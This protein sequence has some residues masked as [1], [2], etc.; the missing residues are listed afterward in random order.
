MTARE[1]IEEELPE[2]RPVSG[3]APRKP[4]IAHDEAAEDEP[5]PEPGG[6]AGAGDGGARARPE[7]MPWWHSKVWITALGLLGASVAPLTAWL[8]A[9]QA[10]KLEERRQEQEVRI[11]FFE[12]VVTPSIAMT[13]ESRAEALRYFQAVLPEGDLKKW[14][15]VEYT[16]LQALIADRRR[17]AEE[18]ALAKA[19]AAA[20]AERMQT[21]LG[22]LEAAEAA[23][24][25]SRKALQQEID[26][27]ASEA[28]QSSAKV[29]EVRKRYDLVERKILQ[30]VPPA[31]TKQR[32][33][34]APAEDAVGPAPNVS[35]SARRSFLSQSAT[36]TYY[37]FSVSLEAPAG[38]LA[39]FARVDYRFDHPTFSQK[40][41]ASEDRSARF[42]VS[43]RGW[44]CLTK[45]DADITL[46]DGRVLHRSFDMCSLL[47]D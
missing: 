13:P 30:S 35:F 15:E 34:P 6:A 46:V 29:E 24:P 45:V 12:K 3:R 43:Y 2:P 22:Q 44:G 4:V 26:T 39:R 7:S 21:A 5:E 16:S 19:T 1:P 20:A 33:L 23:S 31:L 27:Q 28:K 36:A 40:A 47:R 9:E 11:E 17:A 37:R 18:E 8:S 32:A 38:E 41:Y 14:A 25:E 42:E 10:R